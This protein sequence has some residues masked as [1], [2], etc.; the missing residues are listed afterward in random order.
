MLQIGKEP[1]LQKSFALENVELN[2]NTTRV[3]SFIK[4]LVYLFLF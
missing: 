2:K 3:S 4:L 1:I